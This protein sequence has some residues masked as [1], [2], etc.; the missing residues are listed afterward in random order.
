MKKRLLG[1][2]TAVLLA[3]AS[4]AGCGTQNAASSQPATEQSVSTEAAAEQAASGQTSYDPAAFDAK[5]ETMKP[6]EN[7]AID[8]TGCDTFTQIVEKLDDGMGYANTTIWDTE[9]LLVSSGTYEWEPGTEAAIDA[10]IFYYNDDVPTYLAT[11][12]AGGTAYPLSVKDGYLYVGGNHFITKYLIDS[13]SLVEVEEGYYEYDE[14]G[15]EIGYYRTCNSQFED[16]DEATAKS[17]VEGLFNELEEAD[18]I[19]FQTVGAVTPVEGSLPQYEYPGPELFYSVLYQYLTDELSKNYD[20]AQVSIPCP[21][22]VAED[23][24]DKSDIRVYGNFWILNYNLDGDTLECVSGGSYPGCVHIKQTDDGYEVTS[25][26]VVADGSDF[27]ESAKKI[28]GDHYDA[29]MKDGEDEKTRDALR[30]QIIANYAAA[31]NLDIK[32]YQD[33]GWDPVTLPEENIDSF[34]SALN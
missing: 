15:E 5:G 14:A 17:N 19:A 1:S 11:V 25:M 32:A 33:E 2:V 34:Y 31:N 9:V 7:S 26:D 21:V 4:L 23:D 27:T 6:E 24:S 22:I 10:E 13:G 16:Y 28:F 3:A 30:A 8:I 18:V 12:T 20:A 29:F